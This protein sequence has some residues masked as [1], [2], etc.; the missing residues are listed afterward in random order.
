M[1]MPSNSRAVID[2]LP[3]VAE[4]V[5]LPWDAD[6]VDPVESLTAARRS[7]GDT[8]VVASGDDIY[9]FTFS[10]AGVA[11]FYALAEES[12]SKGVADWRMLRRKLP[13]EIF[14]G[15]RTFP[16]DLFGR[17]DVANYLA[18]L[19]AALDTELGELGDSGSFDL[20]EFTRRLGHR[21]GMRSWGGPGCAEGAA[22]DEL[23]NAF[24]ALDGSEAFVH[25]DAMAA[26]AASD[27]RRER[28][29]LAAVTAHMGGALV[30]FDELPPRRRSEEYPLF[31]RIVE[32]WASEAP[33]ERRV[34]VAHDVALVH[35]ASMSNLIAALGWAVVDLL[36]D[37]AAR[38]RVRSGDRASPNSA[39]SNRPVW[40]SARS[41]PATSWPRSPSTAGRTCTGSEP[42]SPSPPSCR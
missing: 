14:A 29:A 36:G 32:A 19:D 18:N 5:L 28:D 8:F 23:A 31:D 1:R 20:F 27:Y 38:A 4:G 40:R 39:P 21:I 42:G 26:V 12:A 41:W 22:F 16:H 7:L 37:G 3:P 33:V 13:P 24:D 11:S 34:G 35:I 17:S 30:D 15:R 9:L 6:G 25:P 10:A 2:P